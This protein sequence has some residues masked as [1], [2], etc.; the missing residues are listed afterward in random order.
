MS[1]FHLYLCTWV[2]LSFLEHYFFPLA[3]CVSEC[4]SV[5]VQYFSLS[6]GHFLHFHHI[7]P[8]YVT[9]LPSNSMSPIHPYLKVSPFAI[10]ATSQG[11][12]FPLPTK[13]LVALS[14]KSQPWGLWCWECFKDLF[15]LIEAS[16]V[17]AELH[18]QWVVC[19]I[20][21]TRS[22]RWP[23]PWVVCFLPVGMGWFCERDVAITCVPGTAPVGKQV[24][25]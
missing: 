14:S 3:L 18:E 17:S 13:K 22:D 11:A 9:I 4:I 12:H 1:V 19:W 20:K 8:V 2:H 21:T 25:F 23:F 10:S 5:F 24:Y 6:V 15:F 7:C 16:V